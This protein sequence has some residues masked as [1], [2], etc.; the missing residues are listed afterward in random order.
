[1]WSFNRPQNFLEKF[2]IIVRSKAQPMDST[3][4]LGTSS[5][6]VLPDTSISL[7]KIRFTVAVAQLVT[8]NDKRMTRR[9]A[10]PIDDKRKSFVW[11]I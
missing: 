11:T 6:Q 4:P 3:S 7:S 5:P 8:V 10:Q 1:V 2:A 9:V